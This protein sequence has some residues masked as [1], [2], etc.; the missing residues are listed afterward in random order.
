MKS[1]K[2][3]MAFVAMLTILLAAGLIA[4]PSTT[5]TSASSSA[6]APSDNEGPTDVDIRI[7]PSKPR[8]AVRVAILSSSHFDA[9]KVDPASVT[10]AGM[11]AIR[12]Q[13]GGFK[14][15]VKDVNADDLLDLV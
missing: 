4:L 13:S 6:K 10:L 14:S 2:G 12:K 1:P 11:S 9:T 5:L 8:R 15:S 7:L 3:V